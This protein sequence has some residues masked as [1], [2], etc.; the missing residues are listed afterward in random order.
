MKKRSRNSK[1]RYVKPSRALDGED[2]E[3]LEALERGAPFT[4]VKDADAQ[5]RMLKQSASRYLKKDARISFRISSSDME[6]LKRMAA[7][8]GLPYQTFLSSV[9]HKLTT[10]QL[11]VKR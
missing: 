9:I 4:R 1:L 11:Q 10:G 8:E 3:L 5:L 7:K 6:N 2:M